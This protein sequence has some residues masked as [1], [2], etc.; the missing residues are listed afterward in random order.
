MSIVQDVTDNL[1]SL[2]QDELDLLITKLQA[3]KSLGKRSIAK[4]AKALPKSDDD[5]YVQALANAVKEQSG[6]QIYSAQITRTR[7]FTVF[8]GSISAFDDFL[9]RGGCNSRVTRFAAAAFAYAELYR[10][11]EQMNN[12]APSWRTLLRQSDRLAS[13]IDRAFPHYARQGML[14]FVFKRKKQ[15]VDHDD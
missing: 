5:L 11:I 13:M 7:E 9:R 2:T 3:F 12:G 14:A 15:K 8:K 1:A 4:N 6:E 10:S